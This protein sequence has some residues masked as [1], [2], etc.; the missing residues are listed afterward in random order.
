MSI[1]FKIRSDLNGYANVHNGPTVTLVVTCSSVYVISET[2]TEDDIQYITHNDA[3]KGYLL[4]RYV[5]S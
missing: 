4:S 3:S 2:L 5:S 1:S